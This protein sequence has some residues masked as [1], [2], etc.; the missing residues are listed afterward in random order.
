[1]NPKLKKFTILIFT[2]ICCLSIHAQVTNNLIAKYSFNNGTANDEIGSVNGTKNNVLLTTD[3]FGNTSHALE[4]QNN[5]SYVDVRD[6]F[7]L[8]STPDTV[9][10]FSFWINSFMPVNTNLSQIIIGKYGN[11]TCNP[12]ENGRELF[13]SI[14][15]NQRISFNYFS[16]LRSSTQKTIQSNSTI[17]DTCWHHV[18]INYNGSINSNDGLDRVK[19]FIDN[20]E[21]STTLVVNNGIA[22][23]I[24]NGISHLGMGMSLNSNGQPCSHQFEGKLDDVRIYSKALSIQEIDSLYYEPNPITGSDKGQISEFQILD[25]IIC[26]GECTDFIDNSINCPVSWEWIFENSNIDMT[27]DQNPSDICFLISGT[28]NITLITSNGFSTDT[29]TKTITANQIPKINLG[30]DA[31]ICERDSIHL[32]VFN[33]DITNYSWQDGSTN[34]SLIVSHEGNYSVTI[35]DA[36]GCSSLDSVSVTL[37]NS[38]CHPCPNFGIPNVFTPNGDRAND[39]FFIFSDGEFEIID[40]KVYSRWGNLV[41]NSPEPWDGTFKEE[42]VPSAVYVYMVTLK[43]KCGMKQFTGDITLIR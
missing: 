11:S 42:P 38:L 39:A 36:N 34:S 43:T 9:F 40:F 30:N 26:E 13:I 25:D 28:H 33:P 15:P 8:F 20:V 1:M 7:D 32:D 23:N 27:T 37:D 29:L 31:T 16:N 24:Q 12:P 18:V 17:N 3:R 6:N 10:S 21:E 22:G 14:L 5:N 2:I 19:I 35:T 4:F 41:H